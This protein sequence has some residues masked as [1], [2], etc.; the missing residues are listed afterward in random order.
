MVGGLNAKKNASI[1]DYFLY[2]PSIHLDCNP[3]FI[4]LNSVFYTLLT[5]FFSLLIFLIP[6]NLYLGFKL[7][8]R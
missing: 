7:F 1:K 4:I 3:K 5:L 8:N 2:N 6:I